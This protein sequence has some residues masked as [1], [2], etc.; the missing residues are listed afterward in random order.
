MRIALLQLVSKGEDREANLTAGV[1]ACR[2]AQAL[3]ADLALFP[4][5]WSIGYSFPNQSLHDS[6]PILEPSEFAAQAES[7]TGEWVDTFRELASELEMAIAVTYLEQTPTGSRNTMSLFDR[8]GDEVLR[9]AKVHLCAFHS[10]RSLEAGT[11]FPVVDLDTA[12]GSV[13]VGALIC[14]DREFPEA[15]RLLMLDGAE[16]VL[17]PNACG[18]DDN[19]MAQLRTRSFENMF[20]LAMA[21]YGAPQHNGRSVAFDGVANDENGDS[22]DP[23]II[24]AGE[25][26]GVVIAD[27]DLDR[28]RSYRVREVWGPNYR[29]PE[30]YAPLGLAGTN[31]T[32]TSALFDLAV[33]PGT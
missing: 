13:R 8:S 18:I 2:E 23:T 25:A 19:R 10:E 21:N 24:E 9:Y 26:T 12:A 31:H 7:P 5:M 32:E 27:I 4:E 1:E 17:I 11:E 3:G 15:A 16:L 28:L 14:Y 33:A 22:R 20:A 30:L 29:H 6:A